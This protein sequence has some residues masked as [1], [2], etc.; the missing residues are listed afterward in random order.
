M[1][2]ILATLALS[3]SAMAYIGPGGGMEFFGYAMGLIVMVGFAILSVLMWPVYT[4]LR[5]IRGSKT[6][7]GQQTS[8]PDASLTSIPST[9]P[10]DDSPEPPT[11]NVP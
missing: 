4:L 2:T 6:P 11:P 10:T 3:S 7:A 9:P 8:G 1:W 5:W